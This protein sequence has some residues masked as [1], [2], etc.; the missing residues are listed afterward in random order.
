MSKKETY[1]FE[2]NQ[3]KSPDTVVSG[4]EKEISCRFAE[5]VGENV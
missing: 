5:P 4:E 3:K 2:K 1:F